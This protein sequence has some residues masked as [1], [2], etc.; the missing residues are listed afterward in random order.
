MLL[1][2]SATLVRTFCTSYPLM[3]R[4]GFC[5]K[6][7]FFGEPHKPFVRVPNGYGLAA[8]GFKIWGEASLER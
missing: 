3:M 7:P 2:K 8:S 6:D 5:V 4:V 1:Q